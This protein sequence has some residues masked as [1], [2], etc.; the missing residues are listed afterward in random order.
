MI[1]LSKIP[2]YDSYVVRPS[3]DTI[4]FL[5]INQ[6][7]INNTTFTYASFLPLFVEVFP[8]LRHQLAY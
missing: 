6:L 1:V 3:K 4:T 8:F 7:F 2:P 5:H